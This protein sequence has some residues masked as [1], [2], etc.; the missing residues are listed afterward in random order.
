LRYSAPVIDDDLDFEHAP[1]RTTLLESLRGLG[2][3]ASTAAAD[4]IDNAISAGAKNIWVMNDLVASVGDSY[5][6]FA[7]NGSGM[8][9][10]RLREA[11][12]AGSRDPRKTLAEG[13][14]GRFGL[15]LKTASLSQCRRLTV[16][17]KSGGAKP[18]IRQWDLDRINEGQGWR[19]FNSPQTQA[20]KDHLANILQST[21][22]EKADSGT[23]VMWSNLDRFL[24]L[25]EKADIDLDLLEEDGATNEQVMARKVQELLD[26]AAR[27]F[28]RFL[29]P[30][31]GQPARLTISK[32][33]ADGTEYITPPWDPF[34][35]TEK[36]ASSK[37][38]YEA[39]QRVLKRQP[40]EALIKPIILPHRDQLPDETWNMLGGQSSLISLQ[41][42]Y[43]YREER[44]IHIGGWLD[45]DY[46]PDDHYKLARVAIFLSNTADAQW[47]VPVDKSSVQIPASALKALQQIARAARR[48]AQDVYRG[49]KG[50]PRGPGKGDGKAIVPIWKEVRHDDDGRRRTSFRVNRSHPLVKAVAKDPKAIGALL[51]AIEDGVPY[52]DIRIAM[53][54]RD[55]GVVGITD[56][57]TS[58]EQLRMAIEIVKAVGETPCLALKRISETVAPFDAHEY[59][60]AVSRL[61]E[62]W[63]C[64]W[65][66]D[67]E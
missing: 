48:K 44:L 12:I 36:F 45:L 65:K 9:E 50:G 14:L 6:A 57:P 39:H 21:G 29:T 40:G 56:I 49:R 51:G 54:E 25:N 16:W 28:H 41:G 66:E 18:S 32:R 17:S 53:S 60:E 26:H 2:Y 15:G 33:F 19:L 35:E 46:A 52:P 38:Q 3:S 24:E 13:E 10:E 30:Q 1:P 61:R 20:D 67:H 59:R 31:G 62:E 37:T 64:K 58:V 22:L 23:V 11:M 55:G 5:V 8:S 47:K 43:V 63:K 34:L 42:F 4:I 7:D 27:V